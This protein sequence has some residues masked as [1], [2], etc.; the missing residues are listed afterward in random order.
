MCTLNLDSAIW[1]LKRLAVCHNSA[2]ARVQR[3][4][5]LHND[6]AREL[7][8]QQSL[9]VTAFFF[10]FALAAELGGYASTNIDGCLYNSRLR[11]KVKTGSA[12]T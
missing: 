4:A 3:V 12:K 11:K 2:V 6:S 1:T 10:L 7:N 5:S 9:H 8:P